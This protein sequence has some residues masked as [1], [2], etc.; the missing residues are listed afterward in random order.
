MLSTCVGRRELLPI[1]L[2]GGGTRHVQ[3]PRR[4]SVEVS[5]LSKGEMCSNYSLSICPKISATI[6]RPTRGAGSACA[7]LPDLLLRHLP[8][9]HRQYF[10]VNGGRS[11]TFSSVTSPGACRRRF[12]VDGGRS[13]TFSSDTSRGPGVNILTLMVGALD[14][15]LRHLSGA[16]VNVFTLM[17]G[18]P[19]PSAPAPPEGPSS[20]FSR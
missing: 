3:T 13:P 18:A 19:R 8:R 15:Q 10:H 16:H 17:V 2:R 11:R 20:T 14:L 1:P 6:H 9:A 7:A 4:A 12:H 5:N